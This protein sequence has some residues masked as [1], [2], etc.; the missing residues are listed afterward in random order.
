MRRRRMQSDDVGFA[1]VK[2]LRA[3]EVPA[4]ADPLVKKDTVETITT[5]E[6]GTDP[7]GARVVEWYT[8]G[9]YRHDKHCPYR[10]GK[11]CGCKH[12]LH[13]H[14]DPT[15]E[16]SHAHGSCSASAVDPH[17]IPTPA[18][19]NSTV[20]PEEVSPTPLLQKEEVPSAAEPSPTMVES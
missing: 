15:G 13:H 10:R 18:S 12:R 16:G 2:S 4:A 5:F 6:Y 17:P 8:H 7:D 14:S 3:R 11:A 20:T 19:G 9:K 1:S